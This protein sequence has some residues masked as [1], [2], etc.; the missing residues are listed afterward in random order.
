MSRAAISAL[1][2]SPPSAT[3]ASGVNQ[4][5]ALKSLQ[6]SDPSTDPQH[7]PAVDSESL[8]IGQKIYLSHLRTEAKVL[9]IDDRGK[10]RVD[11]I[12]RDHDISDAKHVVPQDAVALVL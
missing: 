8:A 11:L 6:A 1:V 12:K 9:Q 3:V 2:R 10:T 4:D 7:R 5:P